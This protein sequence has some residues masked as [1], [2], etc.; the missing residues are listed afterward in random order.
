M[1]TFLLRGSEML[2][3]TQGLWVTLRLINSVNKST[4]S[5]RLVSAG[6]SGGSE[7]RGARKGLETVLGGGQEEDTGDVRKGLNEDFLTGEV[8]LEMLES[9][10]CGID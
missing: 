2:V 4:P 8:G 7:D 10:N 3:L 6:F 5:R 1:L 9:C